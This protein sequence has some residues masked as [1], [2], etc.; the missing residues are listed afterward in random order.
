MTFKHRLGGQGPDAK[1]TRR[2]LIAWTAALLG[3]SATLTPCAKTPGEVEIGGQLREASLAGLNG[4]SRMLSAFRGRR[5]IINVWASWCGPCRAESASLER[6]AWADE[7]HQVTVIGIST[8]DDPRAALS[9]LKASNAT[10]SHYID[11]DLVLENMLGANRLPLTVLVDPSGRVVAKV[12]GAK[13]WDSPEM[14]KWVR[15]AFR[16]GST[17]LPGR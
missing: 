9:W 17:A 3:L 14:V 2:M 5:L 4:K 15:E 10:L 1:I 7:T 12:S 16:G 11:R 6:L 13:A 8:D